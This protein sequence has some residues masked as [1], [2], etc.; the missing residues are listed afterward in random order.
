M[1]CGNRN[2]GACATVD[3]FVVPAEFVE[4]QR[5]DWP[6]ATPEASVRDKQRANRV[7]SGLLSKRLAGARI[8][9]VRTDVAWLMAMVL[10]LG[11]RT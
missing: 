4:T 7:D 2:L 9:C 11:V 5:Q 6:S 8:L 1:R 3:K 10:L